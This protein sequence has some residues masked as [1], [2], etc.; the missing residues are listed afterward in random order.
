M[1]LPI[2]LPHTLEREY[3]ATAIEILK[4][5]MSSD[6]KRY[7]L[8]SEQHNEQHKYYKRWIYTKYRWHLYYRTRLGYKICTTILDFFLFCFSQRTTGVV[9]RKPSMSVQ[10]GRVMWRLSFHDH[11]LLRFALDVRQQTEYRQ[12]CVELYCTVNLY[13]RTRTDYG[14]DT[15]TVSNEHDVD[16]IV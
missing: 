3:Q 1:K 10:N 15:V 5:K 12:S 8:Y 4:S 9:C 2:F 16:K 14:I 7:T 6:R 11:V 13:R